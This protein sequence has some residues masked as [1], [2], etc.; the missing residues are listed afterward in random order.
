MRSMKKEPK[1]ILFHDIKGAV[2]TMTLFMDWMEKN[3]YTSQA[4]TVDL[5]PVKLWR[6][7]D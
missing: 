7:P 6:K 4:I 1:V 2:E 5:E 3:H